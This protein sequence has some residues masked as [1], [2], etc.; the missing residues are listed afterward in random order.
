MKR[1]KIITVVLM[2]S[3]LMASLLVKPA[4]STHVITTQPE[5][6]GNAIPG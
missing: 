4:S 3:V 5:K 2:A 1:R 6:G